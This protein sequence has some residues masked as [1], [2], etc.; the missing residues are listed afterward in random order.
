MTV[1]LQVRTLTSH[2]IWT[3]CSCYVMSWLL[4][5]W[6]TCCGQHPGQYLA[7]TVHSCCCTTPFYVTRCWQHWTLSLTTIVG[8]RH[9]CPSGEVAWM[10]VVLLCWHRLR[11]WIQLQEPWSPHPLYFHCIYKQ[12]RTAASPQPC[13]PGNDW[14]RVLTPLQ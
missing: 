14:H 7:V 12:Q 2:G 9:R 1:R 8:H 11:T 13:P 6:F 4:I 10:S 5:E 3:I